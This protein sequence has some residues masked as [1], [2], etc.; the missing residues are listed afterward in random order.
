VLPCVSNLGPSRKEQGR[1][2]LVHPGQNWDS[3][4][5][6]ARGRSGESTSDD[7]KDQ[8]TSVT[9][10][11]SENFTPSCEDW[12]SLH[13]KWQFSRQRRQTTWTRSDGEHRD[14]LPPGLAK[15]DRLPPGLEGQHC[16][17]RHAAP[18]LQKRIQP[19]PVELEQ[20][21]PPPPPDC[22]YVVIGGNVV[23]L[24]RHTNFVT[25]V[26]HLEID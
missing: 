19:L 1:W 9:L 8:V 4:T 15:K 17:A 16:R 3:S 10:K 5:F 14:S 20:R 26:F 6:E 12:F 22:A 24:N 18:G 7:S 2:H 13:I 25:A 23:L 11:P 21:L